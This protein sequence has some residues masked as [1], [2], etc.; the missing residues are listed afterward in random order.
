VGLT[1]N[2]D[3][4]GAFV[5][6]FLKTPEARCLGAGAGSLYLPAG[7]ERVVVSL[8]MSNSGTGPPPSCSYTTTELEVLVFE[9]GKTQ[10][11]WS[12]SFPAVYH[13]VAP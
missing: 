3:V 9:S 1:A 5:Q 12:G 13:F 8:S 2:R 6:V 7:V 10:P 11:I 4:L